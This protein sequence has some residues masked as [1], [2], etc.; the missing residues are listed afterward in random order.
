MFTIGN[1]EQSTLSSSQV[2]SLRRGL[3]ILRL[4]GASEYGLTIRELAAALEL[5]QPTVYKLTATL[6]TSGFIEKSERPVRYSLGAGVFELADQYWKRSL[7][8]RAEVVVRRVFGEL[9][10]YGPTVV[11]AEAPV[12]EVETILRMSPERPGILE[13][14]R[15]R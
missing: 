8:Q 7:L 2:Q 5:T 3:E 15:G 9:R 11:L 6:V 1:N 12:G 10:E 4:L 13:R 14:P